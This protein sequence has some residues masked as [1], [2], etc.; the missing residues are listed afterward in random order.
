MLFPADGV[1]SV[2]RYGGLNSELH[3]KVADFPSVDVRTAHLL[4]SSLH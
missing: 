2:R 1:P 4:S 3:I